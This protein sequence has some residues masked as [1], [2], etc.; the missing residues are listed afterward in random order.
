MTDDNDSE[1]LSGFTRL[2]IGSSTSQPPL[3]PRYLNSDFEAE[4]D[5][6]STPEEQAPLKKMRAERLAKNKGKASTEEQAENEAQLKLKK[7]EVNVV[8]LKVI[9]LWR[10]E[11]ELE[12]K[13]LRASLEEA[14]TGGGST[15]RKEK[16]AHDEKDRSTDS[17]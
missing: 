1:R 11:L 13:A 15:H 16:R 17:D 4:G 3:T 10:E 7:R 2:P 6:V 12:A 14:K 9:R 5:L 8:K